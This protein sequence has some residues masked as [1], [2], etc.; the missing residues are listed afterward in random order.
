M[1]KKI[2]GRR[3]KADSYPGGLNGHGLD[4]ARLSIGP[5]GVH[6]TRVY[7]TGSTNKAPG[8]RLSGRLLGVAG[9]LIFGALVGAGF[10]GY[11]AQ[12][13]FALLHNHTDATPTAADQVRAVIIAA[14]PD[15]GWVAMALVALVAALRGQSSLRARIGVMV[16]FGLSLGAQILYAP[17]TIEGMLVAVI[18]PVTMAWMLE[19]YIVEVR[20]RVAAQR[21]LD[22]DETP[23]LSMVLA[24]LGR[25]IRLPFG[26]PLWLLR[27]CLDR[28]GTWA[29]ARQWVLDVAP[30]APGRTLASIRA[31]EAEAIASSAKLTAEQVREAAREQVDA[32]QEAH[33]SELRK[34]A[35][36]RAAEAAARL[37]ESQQEREEHARLIKQLQAE[38]R[39]S[40]AR[41]E[42]EA[43]RTI[44]GYA[45]RL[46]D[47]EHQ[48]RG[49]SERLRRAEADSDRLRQVET[50]LKER[51]SEL[52]AVR[53]ELKLV[54]DQA[55]PRVRLAALYERLRL[56]GDHRYRDRGAVPELARSWFLEIGVQSEGTARKYLH[57]YLDELGVPGASV[58]E[59]A[60][61]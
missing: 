26:L 4:S 33:A 16:F 55:T 20:R 6:E 3:G 46:Q 22:I 49:L 48:L 23:I 2:L 31:A 58:Q 1:L 50:L 13:L 36:A 44:E 28:K 42:S 8:E 54:T 12:R 35:E 32:L 7:R 18:A 5:D 60:Y 30:I 9:V 38:A 47:T 19:S 61:T 14:L 39:A 59:G 57:E 56:S 51:T 21:G 43:Q 40:V 37:Q 45:G 27:L 11:E 17:H 24:L 53:A 41:T 10:V 25:L 52:G 34:I 15:V 29:G